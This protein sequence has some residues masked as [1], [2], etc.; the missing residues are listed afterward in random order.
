MWPRSNVSK[1]LLIC[2]AIFVLN[3]AWLALLQ[4]SD[5]S[6]LHASPLYPTYARIRSLLLR[7]LSLTTVF[8]FV[9][10][11]LFAVFRRRKEPVSEFQ[12][13]AFLALVVGTALGVLL[14][15]FFKL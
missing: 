6:E 5:R 3:A 12:R 10:Y 11:G 2:F 13:L 4:H 14:L 15:I 1:V 7:P 9:A 8:V